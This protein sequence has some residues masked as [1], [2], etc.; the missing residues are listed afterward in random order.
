MSSSSGEEVL[1]E[2]ATQESRELNIVRR[3]DYYTVQDGPQR[4]AA[5]LRFLGF[6]VVSSVGIDP[7]AA[8]VGDIVVEISHSGFLHKS[9]SL[10]EGY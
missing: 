9:P 1:V 8:R 10:V 2:P 3:F 5:I 7:N 4:G 6:G